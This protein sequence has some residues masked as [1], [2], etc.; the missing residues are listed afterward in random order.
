MS[1]KLDLDITQGKTF[2]VNFR[3][4][5]RPYVYKP[6]TALAMDAP[7]RITVPQHGLTNGWPVAIVGVTG[8][9]GKA[10]SAANSPPRP[11]EYRLARVVDPETLEFDDVNAALLGDASGGHIQFMTPRDL[12]GRSVCMMIRNRVGGDILF[13]AT[14][15]N[16]YIVVDEAEL[17]ITLRIPPTLTE[18]FA[19]T[20]GV[21]DIEITDGTDVD[22]LAQGAVSVAKEVT[23]CG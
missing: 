10:I 4:A 17:L 8:R 18:T 7:L 16:G 12:T 9:G 14:T 22:L 19:W 6:I 5:T 1:L 11:N 20:S 2:T 3:W 21:Y 13:T 23:I 15:D